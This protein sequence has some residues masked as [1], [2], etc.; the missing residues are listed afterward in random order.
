LGRYDRHVSA[1]L[2]EQYFKKIKAPYKR[3][4]WFEQSAHNPPFEEPI[5]FD[6]ILIEQV[7]PLASH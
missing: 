4:I 6:K 5:E 7:L 2:A 3:L 1:A